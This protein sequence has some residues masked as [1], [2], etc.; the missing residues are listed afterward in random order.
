MLYRYFKE[1]LHAPQVFSIYLLD[2]EMD[3]DPF[4]WYLLFKFSMSCP[5][6][7]VEGL[8]VNGSFM[9]RLLFGRWRMLQKHRLLIPHLFC[10]PNSYEDFRLLRIS[11][12]PDQTNAS[13]GCSLSSRT[14]F[15]I[16]TFVLVLYFVLN[17]FYT[18]L[19]YDFG[20]IFIIS[21]GRFFYF[22]S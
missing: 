21:S 10:E 4:R 16:P 7:C 15:S 1:R 22:V 12:R 19:F 2:A 3:T 5:D 20:F 13:K 14:C 11:I 18:L 9:L 6:Y 8:S 17:L